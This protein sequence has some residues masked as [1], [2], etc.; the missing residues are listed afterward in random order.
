META[1][2]LERFR[3]VM[4]QGDHKAFLIIALAAPVYFVL[5][6][7]LRSY[8]EIALMGNYPM[9]SY[10]R[11]LHHVLWNAT[12]A[13]VLI[14]TLQAFTRTEPRKLMGMLFGVT[15]MT[16]PLLHSLASGAPLE[17]TYL[18][19]GVKTILR[20][21]ATCCLYNP[22]NRPLSLE[23]LLLT[24]GIGALCWLI[25]GSKLKGLGAFFASYLTGTLT[26]VHWIGLSSR[27]EALIK[28][29]TEL[30][31][32]PFQ[33]VVYSMGAM[34]AALYAAYKQGLFQQ[35][36]QA[37]KRSFGWGAAAWVIGSA[38]IL[39][40]GWRQFLFDSIAAG[41]P[42]FLSAAIIVRLQ[43]EGWKTRANIVSICLLTLFLFFQVLVMGPMYLGVQESLT[44]PGA[45]QWIIAP[46]TG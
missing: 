13:L 36:S 6:S 34:G 4:G 1:N 27:P 37:W 41:L 16:L 7:L 19:G 3:C 22:K 21:I 8:V 26:A 23:M 20:D 30:S 12:A 5:F 18:Q 25:T 10:Y 28:V 39:A 44:G 40:A 14:M 33:A 43:Q 24:A 9:F 32:H 45:V 2:K 15:F 35:D 17:L 31:I 38:T 46:V 29:H 42:L 11:G